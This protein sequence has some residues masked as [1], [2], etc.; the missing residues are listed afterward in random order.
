MDVE[1]V[2]SSVVSPSQLEAWWQLFDSVPDAR[3]Y[4][5]PHWHQCIADYLSPDQLYLSFV[6]VHGQLQMVMPMCSSRGERHRMHPAHDHLS[7]NDLLIHP[8]LASDTNTLLKAIRLSLDKPGT[9]WW[10]WRVS[11]LAHHGVLVQALRKMQSA[12][13]NTEKN[14]GK[15]QTTEENQSNN[16]WLKQTRQAASF[17]C[18][19]DERAPTGKLRRNLRRL[20]KQLSDHGK[21]RVDVVVKPE[22]LANAYEQFLDIEASGWKG[23]GNRAP[24]IAANAELKAFYQALLTP[25]VTGLN[26]QINL[27]WCEEECVAAQFGIRTGACLSLLKIGYNET[28]EASRH[29]AW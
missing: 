7:L 25:C 17:N 20:R 10:D 1:I 24:A 6:T 4:H 11:N 29:S 28:K 15:L 18:T 5:H 16:W 19:D 21:L 2:K 26:P 3:F 22:Q 13:D 27:L 9:N 14:R 12:M 23:T 8:A